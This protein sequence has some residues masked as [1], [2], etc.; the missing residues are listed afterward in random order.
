MNKGYQNFKKRA[1]QL[2]IALTLAGTTAIGANA[3]TVTGVTKANVNMRSGAGTKYKV[4]KVVKANKTVT[5]LGQKGSWYK[6]KYNG[7]TGYISKSYVI[8]KNYTVKKYSGKYKTKVALTVRK[9][10]GT[11]YV[12]AGTLK[13]G[14]VVTVK[15]K[16]SNGWLQITYKGA[17]RYISGSSKYVVKYTAPVK[18][19][20]PVINVEDTYTLTKGE[21]FEYAM[22]N[23]TATDKED[24]DITDKIDFS[25]KV[26]VNKVGEYKVTLTVTDKGGKTATKTV[27]VV[28]KD[29]DI[30]DDKAPVIAVG[31]KTPYQVTQNKPF[32][33][34]DLNATAFD[35][36]ESR[37]VEITYSYKDEDGKAVDRI[38][39]SK[40]GEYTVT[41]TAKDK[42]GNT[43]TKTVKVQVV[44]NIQPTISCNYNN[45]DKPYYVGI[46]EKFDVSDLGATAN[47]TEDGP[48][49]VDSTI[50]ALS[51]GT[52]HYE[53]GQIDTSKAGEY[54]VVLTAKD[55]DGGS[56]SKSVIVKVGDKLDGANLT[57][58]NDSTYT[59]EQGD[60]LDTSD[61]GLVSL[62]KAKAV[63]ANGKDITSKIVV[64]YNQDIDLN[65]PNESG[66]K[67]KFQ[68]TA[69]G[70]AY[71]K[72]AKVVVNPNNEPKIEF[73][74]SEVVERPDGNY[75]YVMKH[76]ATFDYSLLKASAY[77]VRNVPNGAR[78]EITPSL[79]LAPNTSVENGEFTVVVKAT[80]SKGL[81]KTV[82]VYVYVR[83]YTDNQ[84]APVIS[85]AST[86]K[87][88]KDGDVYEVKFD[89]SR[90]NGTKEEQQDVLKNMIG[91]KATDLKDGK[92]QNL[93]SKITYSLDR[94]INNQAVGN[95]YKLTVTVTDDGDSD[96]GNKITTTRT[97][98][99]KVVE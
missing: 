44:R 7:K 49:V 9:G 52:R 45:T 58:N 99:I 35:K 93:T 95:T 41:L 3:A 91:L 81:V 8:K 94:A 87:E 67:I 22:L 75:D 17:T 64:L 89:D 21:D 54:E 1:G 82:N 6:V 27:K 63:D 34:S 14:E 80:D 76:N 79:S 74:N 92:E 86:N 65:K 85:Y 51:N 59:V 4:V 77:D 25:G 38:N 56:V 16:T 20:A 55:T 66:Y 61:A 72:D 73:G 26:N 30:K 28:V 83:P 60:K 69:S 13:K 53:V 46:N 5:I 90:L 96:G 98:T 42:A 2:A 33:P 40:L 11:N 39:T 15:G 62:F 12:K 68:V 48:L 31:V 71:V 43:A 10:P 97:I 18:N 84:A 36:E 88:V 23:A 50:Y 47:D 24:G 29:V 57:L 32:K 37:T 78:T 70:K 19:N